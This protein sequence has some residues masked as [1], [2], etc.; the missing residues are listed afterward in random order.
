MTDAQPAPKR[1]R[2]RPK[3][4]MPEPIPDT[5]ENIMRA[6]LA[7]PPKKDD[8]WDYLKKPAK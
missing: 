5:P 3:N 1:P 6:L 4:P 7:T 2:G 8:E